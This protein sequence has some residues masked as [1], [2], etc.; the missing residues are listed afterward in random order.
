VVSP[1]VGIAR[2]PDTM[3]NRQ[4]ELLGAIWGASWRTVALVVVIGAVGWLASALQALIVQVLLATIVAAGMTP[5]VDRVAASGA[6]S[7]GT[8]WRPPRA[9]AVLTIYAA[10]LGVLSLV[11]AIVV[12]P[13]ARDVRDLVPRLPAIGRQWVTSTMVALEGVP[14]LAGID[15][16]QGLGQVVDQLLQQVANLVGQAL[17][18]V[19]FAVSFLTTALDS[20]FVLILALYLT[21]DAGRIRSWLLG[22][23][24][25]AQRP[26]ASR[27]AGHVGTR[28][29]G[30]LRGQILLSAII[31]VIVLIGLLA[32]GV[33]YAVLLALVAAIGEAIP[34]VGPILSAVPAVLVGLTQSPT[35]GL[36]VLALYVVV[37]QLENHLIVPKVM[38]RAVEIHPLAIMLALLAGSQLMGITGAILSVPVAA[39]IAVILDEFR[40]G[41]EGD[42]PGSEGAEPADGS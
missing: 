9:I 29:G 14:F 28:L 16:A 33:P 11:I 19:Q 41:D 38:E 4:D 8:G 40:H 7:K 24:P 42:A 37:Q 22:F 3:T 27:L 36:L 21:A 10:M 12:P 39:A 30:W 18:V 20:V 31:G 26:R 35:T 23:V 32:L 13:A 17:K 2:P 6:G 1:L 5:L 15:I 34:M 25:P